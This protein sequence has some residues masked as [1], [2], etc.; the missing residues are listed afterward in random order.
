MRK[1]YA[2]KEGGGPALEIRLGRN[3]AKR[4]N[5][6]ERLGIF[7]TVHEFSGDRKKENLSQINGFAVDID[8]G[9]KPAMVEKLKRGL[10][11]SLVIETKSGYHAY[12]LFHEPIETTYSEAVEAR[13][14][15]VME[16]R[17]LP[18]YGA[19]KNAKDLCRMLR[20]PHFLHQK[21]PANPF[22]IEIVSENPV[23]YS[24]AQLEAFYPDVEAERFYEENI[25]Q[26][27]RELKLPKGN[28]LFDR[29]YRLDCQSALERLSGHS[30][31]S[32]EVFTFKKTASGN[33]NILV[34]GKGTSC[35]VDKNKRIGSL[36]KG[37]P[38]VWQWLFWY[39]RDHKRVYQ[40]VREVFGV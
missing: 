35:W 13:Y 36:D 4:L 29:I 38:T 1:L 19:D 15:A 40:V 31:V 14:R 17:L 8:G 22:R 24:W 2:M 33:L 34:N 10:L 6:T 5:E 12:W 32:G 11:P 18:F 30:A 9:D 7:W 28:D 3:E 25:T 20:V 39:L 23:R 37:G 21:D 27:R 26:A 16:K